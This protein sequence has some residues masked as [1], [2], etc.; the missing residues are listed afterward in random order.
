MSPALL[1]WGCRKGDRDQRGWGYVVNNSG[2]ITGDGVACLVDSG[3]VVRVTYL[4]DVCVYHGRNRM[5][6]FTKTITWPPKLY[7]LN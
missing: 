6:A 4:L 1:G 2:L 3:K 5:R 7:I